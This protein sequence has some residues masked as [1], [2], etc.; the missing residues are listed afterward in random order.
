ML[1]V[2]EAPHPALSTP[3]READ[4]GDPTLPGLVEDLVATMR[5]SAG[6]VGLAANQVGDRRRVFVVD[7]TGHPRARSSQG[8]IVLVNPVLVA[9]SRRAKVREGCL[10][11]PHL[12]GDLRRAD[13]A[14][15]SGY[16]PGGTA[17]EVAAEGLEARA[18]QHELDHL[19][20]LLFL[21]R[22]V[23]ATAVY[24]RVRYQ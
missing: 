5:A 19:D 7:V 23:S 22:V 18:L 6:C 2:V 9:S 8:L 10:S 20:G 16:L 14:T 24:P 21:D 17:V 13:R 4:L 1:P 15:V 3:C 12:T 11:V